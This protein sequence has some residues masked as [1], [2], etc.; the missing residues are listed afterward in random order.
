MKLTP[1]AVH[2]VFD[3]C[4][5]DPPEREASVHHLV[6]HGIAHKVWFDRRKIEAHREAIHNMLRELPEPFHVGTGS[7]WS[8]LNACTDRN[9]RLWTGEHRTMEFLFLLG[10]AGGYVR[11]CMPRELWMSLPGGMPYY[12]ID[13]EP[14]VLA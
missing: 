14:V 3:A 9:D 6:V 7:G 2:Q 8:F 12:E 13:L 10:I 11:S 5:V 4:M 1:Q